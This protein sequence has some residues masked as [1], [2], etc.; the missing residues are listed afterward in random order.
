ME[1]QEARH[2]R[3]KEMKTW[4]IIRQISSYLLFISTLYI[5]SCSNQNFNASFQVQH[6]QNF[7]LNIGDATLD[8][9]QVKILFFSRKLIMINVILIDH[10]S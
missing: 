6:L 5:I 9:T 4:S 8:Y 1:V 2:L 10:Y 3:L 7:F